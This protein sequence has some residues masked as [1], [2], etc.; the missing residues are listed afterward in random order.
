MNQYKRSL[1]V[2]VLTAL[3]AASLQACVPA[4]LGGAMIGGGLV[5]IDRRT[6]G[7]QIEDET[8]ELR[9]SARVRELG[10]KGQISI[11]S[12]NRLVLITGEVQTAADKTAV[13][14][15]VL[16]VDNVRS[17]VNDLTLAFNSGIGA[18]AGDAVLTAKVKASLVEAKDLQANAFKV[19]AE[20]GVIYLLGRVTEREAA[21][22]IEVARA[23]PGVEKVVRVFEILTEAE[24]TSMGRR[25]GAGAAAAAGAASAPK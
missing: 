23:V 13:E 4:L 3:A 9:A 2:V 11:T 12:Y 24:I 6:A 5:A 21:R 17:V 25:T 15:A 14:K 10:T 16:T 22:G 1:K 19:V 7:I 18:R 8:I 20:R